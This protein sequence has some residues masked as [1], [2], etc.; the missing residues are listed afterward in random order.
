MKITS[1]KRHLMMAG[2]VLVLGAAVLVNWYYTDPQKNA[3]SVENSSDVN[4]A[5]GK[6]LGDAVY[7]NST[8]INDEYFANAK[9]S[10]DES[11]DSAVATL[12]EI[13]E[14]SDVDKQSVQTAADSI[15]S[16]TNKKIAQV[17]IENL[18]TA[19]TGSKCVTVISD[20]NV[21]IIVSDKVLNDTTV[22]QIK[23]IVMEN[24]DISAEKISI[25]GA[26]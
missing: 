14:S 10:R 13:I 25:I 17:N 6:N 1:K 21:E 2:L 3:V 16:I 7:V 19:K 23:E 26:K 11:Y 18:I 12:K 15:N 9:L 20:D 22:L 8:D 4:E 5:N 24:S